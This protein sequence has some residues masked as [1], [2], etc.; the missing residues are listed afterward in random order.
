V[1]ADPTGAP[2]RGQDYWRATAERN[3]EA[4][5]DATERLLQR[6]RRVTITAVAKEARLS[7]V[8]VYAHFPTRQRLLEGVAARS[9]DAANR[10][11]EAADPEAGS[12]DQALERMIGVAWQVLDR[13]AALAKATAEQL[14]PER[15]R[16]VHAPALAQAYRLIER[17]QRERVF[18]TDVSSEWLVACTYALMHAAS[19]EVRAG[20]LDARSAPAVLSASLSDLFHGDQR[21]GGPRHSRRSFRPASPGKNQVRIGSK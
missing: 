13:A 17:G 18:R 2:S 8:T 20:R 19:D 5:C 21:G 14:P 7:R 10:A 11:L 6:G 3:I 15:R 9:V 16:K 1:T 12:P 4:I